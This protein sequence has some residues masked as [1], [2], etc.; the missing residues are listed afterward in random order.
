MKPATLL[1]VFVL[2]TGPG[3]SP[4]A[5]S[6]QVLLTQEEAL[7]L[8]FPD[9]ATVE[10]R[11]AYLTD[12]QLARARSLAGDG[13]PVEHGVLT[14]YVGRVGGEPVGVAYF[15]AHRVR[16]LPEVLMVVVG[17]GGEVDAVEV[18]RF[19]EPPDYLAPRGWLDQFLRRKLDSGLSVKGDIA[20]IT[21][22]TLTSRA[23]TDAVRRVLALHRVL[24]P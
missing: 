21:G 11:T 5:A 7:A 22:A 13:V 6:A 15:D 18:L 3:L 9:G 17:P 1:T 4:L 12:E 20:T 8:A 19:A 24:G 10:R 23:V 14:Y 2:L 16:T